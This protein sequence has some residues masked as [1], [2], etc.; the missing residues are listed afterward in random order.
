MRYGM[1]HQ[2]S[3]I[4]AGPSRGA[5]RRAT[6]PFGGTDQHRLERS[7]RCATRAPAIRSNGMSGVAQASCQLTRLRRG[8]SRSAL[9]RPRNRTKYNYD[10]LDRLTSASASN[11]A[12][13]WTYDGDGNRLSQTGTSPS[14]RSA[15][16][17]YN[18]RGRLVSVT[19]S[20][21]SLT[22]IYNALDQRIVKASSLATTV[23]VYDEAGHML[24][25]YDGSGNLIE[26]TVWMGD[27]PVATLQPNGS[28]GINVFY[29]HA[30]HLNTPKTITRP[31]D[32]AIVWR[33]DQDPFGTVAPNP[34]PSGI[35]TFPYN[36]RYPG[37]YYDF[38]TGLSQN[39]FRDFDPAVGKYVESDPIGLAGGINPDPTKIR[40]HRT[41][42]G[43]C[44]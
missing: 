40:P 35:G 20:T 10:S 11:A 25:E 23:F 34:N 13:S 12:L 16:L 37:Q 15:T 38:E 1:K 41:A 24:G 43:R 8:H 17:S 3:N 7:R 14:D 42:S 39:Y 5:K 36:L 19:T 4:E 30:D 28:G 29:V 18:N 32:S 31:S 26:E 44:A 33:W 27:L 22:A 2:P 6:S 9:R 21:D